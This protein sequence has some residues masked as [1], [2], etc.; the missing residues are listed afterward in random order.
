[1]AGRRAEEVWQTM[2]DEAAEDEI[3]RAAATSVEQAEKDLAEAG[4]D[5]AAER[6]RAA[7]FLAGLGVGQ[8]KSGHVLRLVPTE[9]PVIAVDQPSRTRTRWM[10]LLAAAA[11]GL[12]AV[13]A[14]PVLTSVSRP[15]PGSEESVKKEAAKLRHEAFAACDAHRSQECRG[16]LDQARALDPAGDADPEVQA[17]RRALE[18]LAPPK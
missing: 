2:V 16:K 5:L 17:R 9:K 1:M 3:D 15:G 14:I 10:V 13:L 11:M 8:P 6:A 7:A 12:A 18:G 4:F